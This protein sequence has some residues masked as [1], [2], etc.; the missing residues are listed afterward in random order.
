MNGCIK[1][2]E[3]PEFMVSRRPPNTV[4]TAHSA[5]I[6]GPNS[7]LEN[8]PHKARVIGDGTMPACGTLVEV[9]AERRRAAM[10][11]GVE[12]FEVQPL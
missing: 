7:P 6:P 12:H 9:A 11:N 8:T 2:E 10:L 3:A 4:E 1:V 5:S